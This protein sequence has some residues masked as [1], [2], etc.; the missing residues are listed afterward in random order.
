MYTQSA[1]ECTLPWQALSHTHTHTTIDLNMQRTHTHTRFRI[2]YLANTHTHTLNKQTKLI[3]NI[4]TLLTWIKYK[5]KIKKSE[6][7]EE[8]KDTKETGTCIMINDFKDGG[9]YS[10]GADVVP[11]AVH[12]PDSVVFHTGI[13]R[14][15]VRIPHRQYI[16][17][18]ICCTHKDTQS[19]T[20]RLKQPTDPCSMHQFMS[21]AEIANKKNTEEI[22]RGSGGMPLGKF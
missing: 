8:E 10:F 19:Y 11:S 20:E 2:Y 4:H 5:M 17:R 7:E 21:E 16:G 12:A 6:K 22:S 18:F 14:R 1:I 15:L 9:E 13:T 3:R